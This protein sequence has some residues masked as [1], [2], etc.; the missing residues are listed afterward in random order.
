M[1]IEFSLI[2]IQEV[3]KCMPSN[4]DLHESRSR[5]Q[6]NPDLL[7]FLYKKISNCSFLATPTL[8]VFFTP[9]YPLLDLLVHMPLSPFA[10]QH[11][12]LFLSNN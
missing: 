1:T 11:L 6:L 3:P 2:G 10:I 7:N 4:D 12:D 8:G 9:F 5:T